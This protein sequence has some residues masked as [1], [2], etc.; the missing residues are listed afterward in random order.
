MKMYKWRLT[1]ST[2]NDVCSQR[3]V[4]PQA[5]NTLTLGQHNPQKL[6]PKTQYRKQRY[7]HYVTYILYLDV[8]MFAHI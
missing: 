3:Q 8:Y 5:K 2:E 1:I 4:P 6:A 7:V